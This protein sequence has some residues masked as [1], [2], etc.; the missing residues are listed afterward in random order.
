MGTH[1]HLLSKD[2]FYAN[3]IKQQEKREEEKRIETVRDIR[4]SG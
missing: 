3:L 1:D 4:Q 2:G